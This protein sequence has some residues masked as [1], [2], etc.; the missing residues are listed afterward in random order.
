MQF[1][2]VDLQPLVRGQILAFEVGVDRHLKRSASTDRGDEVDGH[3]PALP[4]DQGYGFGG[5]VKLHRCTHDR[6]TSDYPRESPDRSVRYAHHSTSGV[7]VNRS[8]QRPRDG[9]PVQLAIRPTPRLRRPARTQRKSGRF[10]G[11]TTLQ[12]CYEPAES[13]RMVQDQVPGRRRRSWRRGTH[14]NR[15]GR[16]N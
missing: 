4:A 1:D 12:G 5:D 9:R 11:G 10:R 7:G 8:H 16:R 2:I 15:R 6:G 13:V 14:R 3:D